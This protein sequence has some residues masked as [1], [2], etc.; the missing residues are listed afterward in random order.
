MKILAAKKLSD[1]ILIIN[2]EKMRL[3]SVQEYIHSLSPEINYNK[4]KYKLFFNQSYDLAKNNMDWLLGKFYFNHRFL[5]LLV[6][7]ICIALAYYN[8]KNYN[9]NKYKS[10]VD[11][12]IFLALIFFFTTTL[13]YKAGAILQTLTHDITNNLFNGIVFWTFIFIKVSFIP[14][15]IYNILEIIKPTK[16]TMNKKNVEKLI[17]EM[18]KKDS[19]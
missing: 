15:F 12:G 3:G 2:G 13:P 17:E 10:F 19:I 14:I 4:D 6:S 18:E 9:S 1:T 5:I 8:F 7:I 16:P 11:I